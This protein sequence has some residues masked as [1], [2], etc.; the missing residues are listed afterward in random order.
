MIYIYYII[1]LLCSFLLYFYMVN[2]TFSTTRSNTTTPKQTLTPKI[3][4]C[5][6][7]DDDMDRSVFLKDPP[8]KSGETVNIFV[9]DINPESG[10][11]QRTID[12]LYEYVQPYVN[13]NLVMVDSPDPPEGSDHVL[14]V[15]TNDPKYTRS[16]CNG[17]TFGVGTKRPL[18]V[19]L[20]DENKRIVIHEFG[21]VLGLVHEI[22]H[23]DAR[24]RLDLD[25]LVKVW[26][27]RNPGVDREKAMKRIRY[28]N[29][30]ELDETKV[31]FSSVFDDNSV[32]L[33]NYSA[34]VTLDGVELVG[35]N[36]FSE[37]DKAQLKVMYP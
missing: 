10:F 6:V 3:E 9:E 2:N 22:L 26:M 8:F 31:G 24:G 20:N 12:I 15:I 34:S 19:I 33:Y 7:E 35:G 21:H 14:V 27:K 29:A 1:I 30:R 17:V 11:K 28:Q 4:T 36:E 13:L 16:K 5:G 37:G 25:A 23:P 18:I 32:M